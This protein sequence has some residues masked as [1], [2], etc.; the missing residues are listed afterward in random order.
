MGRRNSHTT[1]EQKIAIIRILLESGD[2]TQKA[3]AEAIGASRATVASLC[4]ELIDK[5]IIFRRNERCYALD[6]AKDFLMLKV[7]R[8]FAELVSCD[9]LGG[10]TRREIQYATSMTPEENALRAIGIVERHTDRQRP[11][12][13]ALLCDLEQSVS[14][15]KSFDIALQRSELIAGAVN[16]LFPEASVLYVDPAHERS[17]L[18][19]GRSVVGKGRIERKKM[20][21]SLLSLFDISKPSRVFLDLSG[22]AKDAFGELYSIR[23]TCEK[24]GVALDVA[25]SDELTP[26]EHETVMKLIANLI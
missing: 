15:P 1:Q 10:C 8:D 11:S 12:G 17:L 3:L 26:D 25:R 14:I 13:I 22:Y 7:Y 9:F 19:F 5:K 18:C 16:R 21:A 4:E 6:P 20:E 23:A 2:S 24:A